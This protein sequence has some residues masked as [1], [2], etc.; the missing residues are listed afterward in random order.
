VARVAV[1]EQQAALPDDHLLHRGQQIHRF[2]LDRHAVLRLTNTHPRP[3]GDSSS[4]SL[5]KSGDRCCRT[6]N[7]IPVSGGMFVNSRSS[8]SRPPADAPMPTMKK[9]CAETIEDC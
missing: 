8:E 4:M 9:S 7:A 5:L 3:S 1:V 6:T 2:R